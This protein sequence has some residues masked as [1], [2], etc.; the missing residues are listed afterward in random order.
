MKR[1]ERMPDEQRAALSA[2]RKGKPL[3]PEHR[4][5]VAAASKGRKK[6]PEAREKVAAAKRGKKRAPFS[7]EHRAKLSAAG[8]RRDYTLTW[9]ETPSYLAAHKRH[10]R[11]WT[12][13]GTCTAC[14]T[15]G[16]TEW[17]WCHTASQPG[18]YS[19]KREDY[20]EL[21]KRCHRRRDRGSYQRR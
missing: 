6:T 13:T 19:D 10:L 1:G 7:A 16:A 5:K 4:A 14:G 21:C 12:K 18:G 11:Y 15:I 8:K 20:T 3:S 9:S 17:A 2:A